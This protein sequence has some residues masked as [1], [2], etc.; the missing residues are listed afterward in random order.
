MKKLK[1]L[2][3]RV[4]A[5]LRETFRNG[6]FERKAEILPPLYR[7]RKPHQPRTTQ[8][9]RQQEIYDALA[10]VKASEWTYTQLQEIVR[11]K[12]GTACSRKVIARWKKEQ[13]SKSALSQPSSPAV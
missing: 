5:R 1:N 10:D 7:Y 13:N 9:R 3:H 6:E 12:T 11:Q 8:Q 4:A 2:R